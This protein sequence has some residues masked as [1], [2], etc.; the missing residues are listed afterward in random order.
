MRSGWWE[1]GWE[2]VVWCVEVVV[3]GGWRGVCER[4]VWTD[5]QRKETR[6]A[7]SRVKMAGRDCAR[8]RARGMHM[9]S[10]HAQVMGGSRLSGIDARPAKLGTTYYLLLTYYL[11]T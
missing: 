11:L 3:G 4:V 2:W 8:E 5:T 7:R 1:E 10:W 9:L 6:D